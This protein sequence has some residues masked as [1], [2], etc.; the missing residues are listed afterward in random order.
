LSYV[1]T[2]NGE[3][4]NNVVSVTPEMASSQNGLSLTIKHLDKMFQKVS[5]TLKLSGDYSADSV[6]QEIL[7]I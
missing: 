7:S 3:V 6:M 2:T 4:T 5:S 1:W